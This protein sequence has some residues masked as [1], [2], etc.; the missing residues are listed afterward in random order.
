MELLHLVNEVRA[1]TF[2]AERLSDILALWD[3]ENDQA[4]PD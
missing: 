4:R 1:A 2:E 3:C